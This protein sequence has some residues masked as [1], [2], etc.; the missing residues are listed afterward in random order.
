MAYRR[1]YRNN[2]NP[3]FLDM[4]FEIIFALIVILG[5]LLGKLIYRLLVLLSD[6]F[7]N[8]IK[9]KDSFH[10]NTTTAPEVYSEPITS[11]P[12]VEQVNTLVVPE[13]PETTDSRYHLNHSLVT[14][15]EHE[16]LKILEQAVGDRY[17]IVPQVPLSGIVSPN[18]SSKRFTNFTDFN[19]INKKKIDFVLYDKL[20]WTPH[21][22]IELDDGSHFRWDRVQRDLFVND[23]M[24]GVGLGILHVQ[25]RY[26][27][28]VDELNKQIEEKIISR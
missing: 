24:K 3:D 7:K 4:L 17:R 26:L 8:R 13:I 15:T 10:L 9:I 23:V 25:V 20:N 16:F 5:K 28:D 19:K 14:Q 27:Y 18:D 6:I 21:L 2:R 11:S 12:P 22:A 1:Y